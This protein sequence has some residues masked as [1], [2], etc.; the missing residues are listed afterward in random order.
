MARSFAV[1]AEMLSQC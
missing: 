1:K